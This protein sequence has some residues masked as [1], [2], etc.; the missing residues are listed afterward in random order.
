MQVSLKYL[1]FVPQLVPQNMNGKL[2]YK[3]RIKSDYKRADGTCALYLAVYLD[4]KRKRLPLN[5]SVP[6]K[7]FDKKAQ[8]VKKAFKFSKDY[9]LL[10]EKLLADLN[11]IEVNYRLNGDVMTLEKVIE[12][13]Q[14]PSLRVNFNTF[15]ENYLERTKNAIKHSTYRQQKGALSKIKKYK[16][17]I[18]FSEID[19]SFLT[20]FRNYLKNEL[21]NVPST[22]EGT[23]KNF[24]KYLHAANKRGIKTKLAFSDITVK[25]MTGNFTFLTPDEVKMMHEYYMSDFVNPTWKSIL[26]QYLF[27][28]FT[29]L[30]ISDIENLTHENIIDDVLAFTMVKTNKF[31]RLQLNETA[32]GLIG[33]PKVFSGSYTREYINRELK[34]IASALGI[35]KR[36]YYHS[37]RHTFATNYLISGGSVENLQKILG[38][39]EIKTTMVY[40]HIVQSM[41]DKEVKLMDSI[42]K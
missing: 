8:R 40:V 14:Q 37:S 13:L 27:S 26:Q 25:A 12:D 23:I 31:I 30:R 33:H 19:E 28:C 5:I 29:G 22:I 4:Q 24:K 1:D 39:S 15:A 20:D 6:P 7:M 21:K 10:I 11:A 3:I 38:H 42:I 32:K 36:L 9:N 41:I 16:D 18:L 17:P 35:K 34:K 2:S